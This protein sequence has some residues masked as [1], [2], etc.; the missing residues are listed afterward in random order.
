[1]VP[2]QKQQGSS[3]CELSYTVYLA[4]K[5]NPEKAYFYQSQMM[6]HLINCLSQGKCHP[7]VL[8]RSSIRSEVLIQ[9][10][11]ECDLKYIPYNNVIVV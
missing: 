6:S 1:V 9:L 11:L 4:K 7:S 2:V 10:T 8:V 3:D 5:C